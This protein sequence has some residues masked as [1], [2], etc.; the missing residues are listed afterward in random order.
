MLPPLT[1]P[2]DAEQILVDTLALMEKIKRPIYRVMDFTK[3]N[4]QFSD[5][6]VGMSY[7]KGRKGGTYDAD[8]TTVFVGSDDLV[9]LGTDAM[10]QQDHFKGAKVAGLAT[11]VEEAVEI[12][13]GLLAKE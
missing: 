11:S 4:L 8:I 3:T 12:A 5:M 13:R 6:M 7:D 2:Q 1:M 9:K 10:M